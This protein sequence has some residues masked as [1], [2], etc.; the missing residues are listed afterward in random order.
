MHRLPSAA[1]SSTLPSASTMHR[2]DAEEAA[3]VAEPGFSA[4]GAGQRRDQDAAGLGLPPGV[5]DRA[6]A[7]ADDAVV[8]EP[9]FGIDRLADRAEQAQRLARGVFFTGASPSRIR[10][11]I[12]VGAV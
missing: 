9:G 10:A 7:V 8:P 12:A 11:R 2:L 3:C 5:D 1:P 6:A 4:R